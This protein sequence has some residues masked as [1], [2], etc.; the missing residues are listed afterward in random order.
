MSGKALLDYVRA[1]ENR[2]NPSRGRQVLAALKELGIQPVVQESSFPMVRNIVVDL[3][4][5]Q[6]ARRPLFS[7]HY[8]AV[9]GSPGAN[10]NA[11]GVAVLLGLCEKLRNGRVPVRAVFFDREEAWLRTPLL[12]PGLLGSLKYVW[13][14]GLE[15]VSAVYNLEFCGTGDCLCVWPIRQKGRS[16]RAF[17]E[18]EQAA[19]RLSLPMRAGNIPW[20]IMSSD[21]LSFRLRGLRD[22]LTLSLLPSDKLA[23]LEKEIGDIRKMLFRRQDLPEPLSL[24]HTARDSSSELSEASLGLMLAFL[25]ELVKGGSLSP[26]GSCPRAVPG[27]PRGPGPAP[28]ASA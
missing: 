20:F 7:A 3:P 27:Q 10:D 17:K 19:E 22:A 16:L 6:Q 23:L 1:L 18:V 28:P 15:G 14:N 11:S 13:R 24:I 26:G 9:K 8:D 2:D 12:R 21:H 4:P 5:G 25:L